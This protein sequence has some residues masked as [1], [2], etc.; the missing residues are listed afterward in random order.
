MPE[1]GIVEG[2]T[3]LGLLSISVGAQGSGLTLLPNKSAGRLDSTV[4][5]QPR[6]TQSVSVVLSVPLLEVGPPQARR[7]KWNR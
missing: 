1:H 3:L 7:P 4:P 2:T 6:L 5:G